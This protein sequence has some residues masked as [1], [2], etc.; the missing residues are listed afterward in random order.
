MSDTTYT[1]QCPCCLTE[2]TAPVAEPWVCC[3]TCDYD[4]F[5][6]DDIVD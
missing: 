2:F 5:S 6:E 4:D 1:Y 3:P